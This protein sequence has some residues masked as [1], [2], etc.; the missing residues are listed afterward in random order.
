MN[1]GCFILPLAYFIRTRVEICF[2]AC[3]CLACVF[4]TFVF[5][6]N[7]AGVVFWF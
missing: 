6:L 7:W 5:S 2:L 3:E 4:S 1:V